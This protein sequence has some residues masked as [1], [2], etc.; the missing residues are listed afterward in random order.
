MSGDTMTEKEVSGLLVTEWSEFIK[1]QLYFATLSVGVQNKSPL[2]P[3][4][5][6]KNEHNLVY[7]NID[8]T[9][10]YE[11]FY[12]D[13]GPL[14]LAMVYRYFTIVRQKLNQQKKVIHCTSGF[15]PKKRANAAVLICAYMIIEHDWTARQ[16]YTTL[17]HNSLLRYMQFRDASLLKDTEFIITVED[18]VNALY[19]AK[20]YGF[21]DFDDFDLDEYEKLET[22]KDGDINWIVP[23]TLLAFS[24]PHSRE[25]IDKSGYHIHSPAYYFQYFLDN[26]VKHVVRLNNKRTYDAKSTFV[27]AGNIDHTD[28]F[29]PDGTPPSDAILSQFLN[30]CEE[31]LDDFPNEECTPEKTDPQDIDSQFSTSNSSVENGICRATKGAVAVHCK[32]GLGRTGCLIASYIVKHWSFTAEEAIAWIRICRPG[33]IIGAQQEWLVKKQNY[34]REAGELW[35]QRIKDSVGKYK[36]FANGVNSLERHTSASNFYTFVDA[37]APSALSSGSDEPNQI[38]CVNNTLECTQ[39]DKISQ[40]QSLSTVKKKMKISD[41][42]SDSN[43]RQA[44]IFIKNDNSKRKITTPT[45]LARCAS[46]AGVVTGKNKVSS[47]IT[48][49]IAK[50]SNSK[51][52]SVAKNEAKAN[53]RL[54]RTSTAV[55]KPTTVLNDDAKPSYALDT[56]ASTARMSRRLRH[57][58]GV[59]K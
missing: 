43:Q 41:V 47:S 44:T 2:Q 27:A 58:T 11:N 49:T 56:V 35:R 32:A 17:S 33:S 31:F 24:S 1:D 52:S 18:C 20:W 53:N 6:W 50:S 46:I 12:N 37:P 19:K 54:S 38:D 23:G 14:N 8:D 22:V 29:F 45:K 15:D 28:M 30:L 13:F 59:A 5:P 48:M 3:S 26:N 10:V 51:S 25:Y 9:L 40:C 34:L 39:T 7:L 42:Q 55:A 21:F 36:R 16:A 57:Q 4:V